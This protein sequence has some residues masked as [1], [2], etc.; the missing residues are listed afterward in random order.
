MSERPPGGVSGLKSRVGQRWAALKDRRPWVR[1]A[2]EAWQLAQRNNGNQ[3]AAA[4]TYF[5]FLALFPLILLAVSV[6]GFV[7]HSHPAAEHD[8]FQ[9]ITK[10]VPGDLGKTLNT[11]LRTAIDARAGVGIIGLVGVLLTGLGWIG[12]L[13]LAIDAVWGL[14]PPPKRNFVVAK[15]MNLLVLAGLGVGLLVSLGITAVGTSLTH[16]ILTALNLDHLTGV[17]VLVKVL[18]ILLAVAGDFVIFWWMM[19]RLP[20]ITVPTRVAV[21]GAL[22]AAVGFEVLKIVGSYTI[23]HTAQSPTAGPFAGLLA[24]LIWIQL[25]ARYLLFCTAWMAVLTR[26]QEPEKFADPAALPGAVGTVIT[27]EAT[28]ATWTEVAKIAGAGAAV[29][30]LVGARTVHTRRSADNA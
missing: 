16:Q 27:R 12:N 11:S 1:H 30:A 23:A 22:M 13:R 3:Y 5:S 6:A 26:E 8:L 15:V 9:N 20:L 18:G 29:G 19:V 25:V 24:V 10:N 17:T 2:V 4:I 14:D 28:G 21:K 7:L